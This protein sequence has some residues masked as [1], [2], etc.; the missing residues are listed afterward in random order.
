MLCRS[1]WISQSQHWTISYLVY[2]KSVSSNIKCITRANAMTVYEPDKVNNTIDRV[3]I[4]G[5]LRVKKLTVCNKPDKN[6]MGNVVKRIVERLVYRV[7]TSDSNHRWVRTRQLCSQSID[8]RTAVQTR[9]DNGTI[10]D[11]VTVVDV[12][13][14]KDSELMRD[15][16]RYLGH[17]WLDLEVN[18]ICRVTQNRTQKLSTWIY[19]RTTVIRSHTISSGTTGGIN[20]YVSHYH[21]SIV[22]FTTTTT[23]S[24]VQSS[25]DTTAVPT[26]IRSGY[27]LHGWRFFAL[28]RSRRR[29][30]NGTFYTRQIFNTYYYPPKYNIIICKDWI[31]MFKKP[32]FGISKSYNNFE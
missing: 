31:H 25:W 29:D 27:R 2:L 4:C 30:T 14:T 28:R 10:D 13:P 18:R 20:T 21:A 7:P 8:T 24:I 22:R 3:V 5:I 1:F 19:Q 6:I 12:F 9:Y 26:S 11:A 23:S 16:L 32:I 15:T 17:D